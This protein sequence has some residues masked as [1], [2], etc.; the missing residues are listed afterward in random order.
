MEEPIKKCFTKTL[1]CDKSFIHIAISLKQSEPNVSY[2]LKVVGL[3]LHPITTSHLHKFKDFLNQIDEV[4]AY[5]PTCDPCN[6][7]GF[8]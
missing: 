3:K 6:Q 5:S 4:C 1:L 7:G 2:S 8:I